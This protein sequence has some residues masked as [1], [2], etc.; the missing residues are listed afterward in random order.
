MPFAMSEDIIVGSLVHA[1]RFELNGLK[2]KCALG[3]EKPE[4][5]ESRIELALNRARKSILLGAWTEA[6]ERSME[7]IELEWE[8][9]RGLLER[10]PIDEV[11]PVKMEYPVKFPPDI[12]GRVDGILRRDGT[13]P[14]IEYKTWD[15]GFQEIEEFQLLAYCAGL[16]FRF[17]NR[18][19]CGVL[20]YSCPPK[21]IELEFCKESMDRILEV[22]LELL[23]FMRTGETSRPPS[24]GA[25]EG[26]GYMT[27]EH[28]R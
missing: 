12:Y 22:Y 27:C 17:R 3:E 23:D 1:G 2:R 10:L 25:C 28:R 15:K 5:I 24:A 13:L 11:Y 8:W 4:W 26:C 9:E 16:E 6:L 18:V 19:P 7:I 20:Q 21:R 14:P